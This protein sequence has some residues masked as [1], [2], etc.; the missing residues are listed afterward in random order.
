MG[1]DKRHGPPLFVNPG[2][3]GLHLVSLIG[4]TSSSSS[5][6]QEMIWRRS[7]ICLMVAVDGGTCPSKR[8]YVY[9]FLVLG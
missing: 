5:V 1:C 7:E 8:E 9:G 2:W 3:T 6:V 4:Q